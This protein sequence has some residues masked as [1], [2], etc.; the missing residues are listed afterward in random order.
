MCH[1]DGF[2]FCFFFLHHT[3]R[4][5]KISLFI[6]KRSKLRNQSNEAYS[7]ISRRIIRRS[8]NYL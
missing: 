1:P 3:A 5:L 4:Q 8:A 7:S 2:L 6:I